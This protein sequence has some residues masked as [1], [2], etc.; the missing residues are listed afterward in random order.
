MDGN[1]TNYAS[2]TTSCLPLTNIAL[3]YRRMRTPAE[4]LG[5]TGRIQWVSGRPGEPSAYAGTGTGPLHF[6]TIRV[7]T[8]ILRFAAAQSKYELGYSAERPGLPALTT[9]S[10]AGRGNDIAP[11]S[12]TAMLR[13]F[14]SQSSDVTLV[15]PHDSRGQVGP[16]DWRSCLVRSSRSISQHRG[17]RES[18]SIPSWLTCIALRAS[19]AGAIDARPISEYSF[20][21]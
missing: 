9:S 17:R 19:Q 20:A 12:G 14:P 13:H 11:P 10:A 4:E 21:I 5:N 6:R 8:I 18:P 3:I 1:T 2:Q 15:S 16:A 7:G